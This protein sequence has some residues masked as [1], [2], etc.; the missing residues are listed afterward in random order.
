VFGTG[1]YVYLCKTILKNKNKKQKG[2]IK[3][4]QKRE[5]TKKAYLAESVAELLHDRLK[6]HLVKYELKSH[7]AQARSKFHQI[8]LILQAEGFLHAGWSRLAS[9]KIFDARIFK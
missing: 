8:N 1:F 6:A 3:S 4:K 5:G 2:K 9:Q 7:L